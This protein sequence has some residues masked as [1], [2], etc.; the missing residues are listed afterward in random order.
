MGYNLLNVLGLF[1]QRVINSRVRQCGTEMLPNVGL[2]NRVKVLEL[3]VSYKPN[4]KHLSENRHIFSKMETTQ[5]IMESR[6][7]CLSYPIC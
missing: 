2:Q 4:Y 7:N 6:K 5:L 3:S 1:E